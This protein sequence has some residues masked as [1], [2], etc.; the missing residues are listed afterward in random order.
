MPQ[1]TDKNKVLVK[2]KELVFLIERMNLYIYEFAR[3]CKISASCFSQN[4]QNK[5]EFSPISRRRIMKQLEKAYP[6]LT[7]EDVFY[8]ESEEPIKS[9]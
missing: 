7:W 5:K 1:N 9:E 2:S 8:L 4:L 3:R 6:D